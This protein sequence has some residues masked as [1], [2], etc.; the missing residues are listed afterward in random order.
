MAAYIAA[1]VLPQPCPRPQPCPCPGTV[2]MWRSGV[3]HPPPGTLGCSFPSRLPLS[4]PCCPAPPGLRS[5]RSVRQRGTRAEQLRLHPRSLRERRRGCQ[6]RSCEDALKNVHPNDGLRA[7]PASL[8]PMDRDALTSIW[9][10]AASWG[11]WVHGAGGMHRVPGAPGYARGVWDVWGVWDAQG[12]WGTQGAWGAWCT[13]D[14][15]GH[16]GWTGCTGHMGCLGC[17]G[18]AGCS[19]CTGYLG[20]M[21]YPGCTG[22]VGCNGARGM[23]GVHRVPGMHRTQ[24]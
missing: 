12:A 18:H 21:G 7:S 1:H 23:D 2:A 8:I 17:V 5:P 3:T 11:A 24:G 19:G 6:H 15:M 13:Q 22:H 20:C 4:W 16:V 9:A 10:A 14:A